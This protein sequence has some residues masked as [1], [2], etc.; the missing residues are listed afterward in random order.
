MTGENVCK[1]N[2]FGFC[3][4]GK[5]CFRPHENKCCENG[6]CQ[7]EGCPLRHPRKCRFFME[8][9]YCKFGT[10]CRFSHDNIGNKKALKEIDELRRNLKAVQSSIK[11]KED[12]IRGKNEEIEIIKSN[13]EKRVS[14]LEMKNEL[15]KVEI[16]AA[17][18]EAL[19]EAEML[20]NNIA[21]NDMI[22]ESF[23]ER[24]REK[25]GYD[26]D[27]EESDYE[28]NDEI[29]ENNR[30]EFRLQKIVKTRQKKKCDICDFRGKTEAGL[31]TH[32]T[33]KHRELNET[34]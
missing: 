13:L 14:E 27:D 7:V 5:Y 21:V 25:Y 26:S 16:K 17:Q 6:A 24:M 4:F 2:K 1:F 31:Q 29:R 8:F 28:S 34:R 3:K 9:E 22:H 11:E 30:E 15:L 20:R 12:V 33:E 18:K 32:K 23:K 10:Y 19:E